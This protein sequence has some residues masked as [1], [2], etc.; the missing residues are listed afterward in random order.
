MPYGTYTNS[1]LTYDIYS[2]N[3]IAA[4]LQLSDNSSIALKAGRTASASCEVN[5]TLNNNSFERPDDFEI[6]SDQDWTDAV[7]FVTE[8]YNLYGNDK[9]W[10]TPTFTLLKDVKGTLPAF[11]VNVAGTGKLTLTG[12]NTLNGNYAYGLS[13]A[14]IVNE[15][16]LTVANAGPTAPAY[17]VNS[18]E[19]KGKVTVNGK[20]TITETLVNT[21]TFTNAG[22]TTVTK[23]TTNGDDK[24]AAAVLTN[25]G[26][27]TATLA[28]TNKANATGKA[29]RL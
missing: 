1:D 2:D 6:A 29:T 11:D 17:T 14:N 12:E 3:G 21:G 19:N 9:N 4:G 23:E 26:K 13:T 10:N 27:F 20:L 8:N 16:T 18:L 7:D 5:Y 28:L 24:K 25:T 15:G 22:E